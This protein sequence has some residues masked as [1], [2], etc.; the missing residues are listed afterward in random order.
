MPGGDR[1]GPIGMGSITGR[2]AGYCSGF[3]AAGYSN[4]LSGR[5]VARG[6][7]SRGFRRGIGCGMGFRWINS[8][9]YSPT[10]SSQ[11]E[12]KLLKTQSSSMQNE[13][14]IINARIKEL[15]P[16]DSSVA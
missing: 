1:T 15:E 2:R 12:T 14:K 11:E 10:L 13:I 5:S 16:N 8:N 6:S 7:G 3:S 4:I 9:I